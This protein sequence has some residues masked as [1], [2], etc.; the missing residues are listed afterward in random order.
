VFYD[1]EIQIHYTAERF[2]IDEE[3]ESIITLN[4]QRYLTINNFFPTDVSSVTRI[5]YK[6]KNEDAP[7]Y[8]FDRIPTSVSWGTKELNKK[9]IKKN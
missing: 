4:T 8:L 9:F 7:T 2:A 1:D 3:T 5:S 6:R